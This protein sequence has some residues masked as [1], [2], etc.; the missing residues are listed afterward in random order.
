LK[1]RTQLYIFQIILS[2]V[3]LVFITFA[4]FSY[5]KQYKKEIDRQIENEISLYKKNI[6][7]SIDNATK[8]LQKHKEQFRSIHLKALEMLRKDSNL[9]LY[10]LK[11]EIKRNY[12]PLY[13]DVEL[14]LVNKKYIIYESTFEKDI[15]LDLSMVTDG[16]NFLDKTAQDGKIYMNNY[17]SIDA[18]DLKHK[19]YSVAK[20]NETTFLEL[21][22]IDDTLNNQIE[23]IITYNSK[24]KTKVSLYDVTKENGF[25][26][27]Y[28][29]KKRDNVAKEKVI[30]STKRVAIAEATDDDVIN[31]LKLNSQIHK[32][33]NNIHTVYVNIFDND[34]FNYLGMSNIVMKIDFDVTD[35]NE[36]M[37]TLQM[38][39]IGSL[40]VVILLF[41]FLL[42][43]INSRFTSPIEKI[44]KSLSNHKKVD[45]KGILSFDNELSEISK[46]YNK[47]F[48]NLD[49]EI[50]RNKDLLNE[51][52][53][54]IADTVHQIR[55]PLSNIMMNGDM[56][57]LYQKDDKLS[58]FIDQINASIN[59]L[60]NSYEN[61]SYVTTF[62]TIEYQS[63]LISVSDIL[64]NRIRFFK[65]I[66]KVNQKEIVSK[67]DDSI[68]FL[69]NDIELERLIDN[70][71]SNA[72]KYA[73]VNKPITITLSK[74]S[75]TVTLEFATYGKPIKDIS[76]LFEKS[77]R[78]ES[79]QRGLGLGLYMVKNICEK[80]NITYSV[81]YL[82][83]Q[84]IFIYTYSIS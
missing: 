1:L 33:D 14:Y 79:S 54:F 69:M 42:I 58:T 66:S 75:D 48:E 81:K 31:T 45:N 26:R 57:K 62:D 73:N 20:L 30:N 38:I 46:K 59:M 78:E 67:I 17:P 27:Y 64:T 24:D 21:G 12:L 25:Y 43:F 11:E 84:N 52:K 50:N 41:V 32:I 5:E 47:L 65:T 37:K 51:N 10:S 83:N 36:F 8:K 40:I 71:I 68:E 49:L 22:F 13:V 76:K 15:G 39:F 44:V 16:K 23:A 19:Y 56:I 29:M 80:Y 63:S 55:T 77:Y 35:Q 2:L 6:T 18:L 72:I 3:L 9:D 82:N 7:T 60:N 53:Q 70:N 34:M 4:Y 61:L 28:L 74:G